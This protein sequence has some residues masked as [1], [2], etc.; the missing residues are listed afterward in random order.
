MRAGKVQ[1]DEMRRARPESSWG[2]SR[3]LGESLH[4]PG[5]ET[6]EVSCVPGLIFCFAQSESWSELGQAG[7]GQFRAVR[8]QH[9]TF[10]ARLVPC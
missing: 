1:D 10:K 4:Q 6:A 9:G 7:L 2:W 5:H 8:Y 3:L